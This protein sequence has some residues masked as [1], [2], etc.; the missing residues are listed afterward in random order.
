MEQINKLVTFKLFN[1][2]ST[3]SSFIKPLLYFYMA[4]GV[5]LI[6]DLYSGQLVDF[7]KNNRYAKHIIGLSVI[8]LLTSD[9]AK[10]SDPLTL[11]FYSSLIYF[12]FLMTTKMDLHW[13][14]AII[15]LLIIGYIYE[16]GTLTKEIDSINDKTLQDKDIA[17]IN[18]YHDKMKTIIII[19]IILI[20]II[21]TFCYFNKKQHQY[22]G[23]F[24][25]DKFMFDCGQKN[26]M[27][28]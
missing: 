2:V 9:V 22:G 28:K 17:N 26:L 11:A 4:I 7:I 27:N 3:R 12:I 1:N 13:S 15:M 24:D 5:T 16:N 19:S 21:G 23:S 8:L 10:I 18:K 20:T 25:L 6:G 14:M